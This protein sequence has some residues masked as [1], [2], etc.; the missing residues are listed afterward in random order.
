MK[1]FLMLGLS[2]V[3]TV[4]APIMRGELLEK[5]LAK[6]IK[7]QYQQWERKGDDDKFEVLV[8]DPHIYW[9]DTSKMVPR[10]MGEI[11]HKG[12]W[13]INV[14]V[15]GNQ[16][17]TESDGVT[18]ITINA[19]ESEDSYL[20]L[21]MDGQI[22]KTVEGDLAKMRE[23]LR[24][25]RAGEF[26]EESLLTIL[27]AINKGAVEAKNLKIS[28]VQD[29]GEETIFE[30]AALNYRHASGATPEEFVAKVK[31]SGTYQLAIGSTVMKFPELGKW[32]SLEGGSLSLSDWR[33]L[34][35]FFHAPFSK[36]MPSMQLDSSSN[37]KSKLGASIWSVLFANKHG[38]NSLV[39]W[40]IKGQNQLMP[41]WVKSIAG[42]QK[43]SLGGTEESMAALFVYN[44]LTSPQTAAF[45]S[46]LPL[47]SSLDWNG[48]VEYGS[49]SSKDVSKGHMWF[50]WLKKDNSGLQVK[51]SDVSTDKG[52]LQVTLVGGRAIYDYFVGLFNAFESS[53]SPL[54][55]KYHI[56]LEKISPETKEKL[57][58]FLLS[59]AD[60]PKAQEKE[61][62]FNVKYTPAGTTIGNKPLSQFTS[63]FNAIFGEG[64]DA[65]GSEK[66]EW[67]PA[68]TH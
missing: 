64:A 34:A 51:F 44:W 54:A 15:K 37:I 7:I 57:F 66:E 60:D 5:Q 39:S 26:T 63:D 9:L 35:A 38:E 59:Y 62:K 1:L 49:A 2:V 28:S 22:T 58:N 18:H 16:A 6:G 17:K 42:V 20:D 46:L 41:D 48:S 12:T 19:P 67:A 24:Q 50:N 68:L 61:L 13:K 56:N 10:L 25:I 53:L 8:R 43:H 32:E 47:Q 33:T 3:F 55:Q 30:T 23:P 27:E 65:K 40:T 45:L 11:D 4:A 21:T 14:D 29:G 52:D 36:G 31:A